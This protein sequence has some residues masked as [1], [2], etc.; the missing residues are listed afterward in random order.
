MKF[1]DL[2][3]LAE[4]NFNNTEKFMDFVREVT[5]M[6][7]SESE[8]FLKWFINIYSHECFRDEGLIDPK[9]LS[10]V[11]YEIDIDGLEHWM[12]DYLRGIPDGASDMFDYLV[13]FYESVIYNIIGQHNSGFIL[14]S[15]KKKLPTALEIK[16]HIAQHM[17]N[18]YKKH[19]SII[20]GLKAF[21]LRKQ[22]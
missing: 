12:N 8:D 10:E 6:A 2:V 20:S 16:K 18:E 21:K 11:D 1:S 22:Q 17:Y 15:D 13:N 9:L 14:A 3:L 5:G 19:K 4:M 7:E